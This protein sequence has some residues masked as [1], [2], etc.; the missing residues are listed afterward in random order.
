MLAV[1][2]AGVTSSVELR[3]LFREN[4]CDLAKYIVER[5]GHSVLTVFAQPGTITSAAVPPPDASPVTS[6]FLSAK[7]LDPIEEDRLREILR[8]SVS[9]DDFLERLRGAGYGVRRV[10]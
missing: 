8:A 10:C 3:D 1:A 7:A 9:V 5:N 4:P 2:V 6:S